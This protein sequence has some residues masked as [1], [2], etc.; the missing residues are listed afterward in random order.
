MDETTTYMDIQGTH[1]HG[2]SDISSARW[3]P[4]N[5]GKPMQNMAV[6]SKSKQ[7]GTR[8]KLIHELIDTLQ[9]LSSRRYVDLNVFSLSGL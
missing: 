2:Y 3:N 6:T 5:L 9:A 8:S 1:I 4:W 7:L